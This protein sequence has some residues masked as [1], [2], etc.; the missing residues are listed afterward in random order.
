[1]RSIL[2]KV[3]T[4]PQILV[5]LRATAGRT[6][7]FLMSKNLH[8]AADEVEQSAA[9]FDVDG[10]FPGGVRRMGAA[11]ARAVLVYDRATGQRLL[12]PI[13][14]ATSQ[15]APVAAPINPEAA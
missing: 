4:L 3:T 2:S 9:A 12:P 5:T 6:L 14:V 1:M 11:L 13:E 10:D 8:D 15:P 7:D